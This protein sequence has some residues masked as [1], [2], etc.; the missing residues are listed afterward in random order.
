[1]ALAPAQLAKENALLERENKIL[2]RENESLRRTLESQVEEIKKLKDEKREAGELSKAQGER[3]QEL[4]LHVVR[5][6]RAQE[7]RINART[8]SQGPTLFDEFTPEEREAILQALDAE[9]E[10]EEQEHEAHDTQDDPPDKPEAKPKRK[11]NAAGS[12]PVRDPKRLPDHFEREERRVDIPE[13]ERICSHSGQPMKKIGEESTFNLEWIPGYFKLV[14]T[15]CEKYG[16]N[17]GACSPG[18]IQAPKP[19]SIVPGSYVT[20]SLLAEVM[21]NKMDLHQPLYRQQ[22]E[23][24]GLGFTV[25]RNTLCGWMRYGSDLLQPLAYAMRDDLLNSFLINSDD[26]SLRV[27]S[28]GSG[29]C[30]FGHIWVYI[31]DHDHPHVFFDYTSTRERDGPAEILKN[32]KGYL[33][34]DAYSGYE[35]FFKIPGIIEVACWSH[36][37][38]YFEGAVP[39]DG[40]AGHFVRVIKQLYAIDRIAEDW[41]VDDRKALRQEK[42]L[43]LLN[44]KMWPLVEACRVDTL[45][46]SKMW[47]ALTYIQNQWKALLRFTEDGRIKLDNNASEGQFHSVGTGRRNWLFLGSE[48]SGKR[49]AILYTLVRTCRRHGVVP[50]VYLNDVL[51]RL[52]GY[53]AKRILD[54]APHNW[55][56]TFGAEYPAYVTRSYPQDS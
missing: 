4:E 33:H 30:D 34:V 23:F 41:S 20:A 27:L 21:A 28:P 31:G 10:A 43:P 3:I 24:S 49:A 22:L 16:C 36:T 2:H 6:A 8:R 25:S 26:T 39:V 18:V 37:L 11:R 29:Q 54:L 32:Y 14:E 44:K 35:G 12:V 9:R 38:R 56:Q 13:E 15:I 50:S 51:Q 46:K 55:K 47:A 40:R 5:L 42:S 17:C 7:R 52:P 48:S 45:P 53:S 19:E 1:M